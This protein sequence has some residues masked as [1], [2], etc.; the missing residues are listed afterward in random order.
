MWTDSD[1]GLPTENRFLSLC[2][3]EMARGGF[4]MA[5]KRKR[6]NTGQSEGD[7]RAIFMLSSSDDKLNIIFDELLCVRKAQEKNE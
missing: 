6:T 5:S 7:N 4:Q 1:F 3:E 2:N